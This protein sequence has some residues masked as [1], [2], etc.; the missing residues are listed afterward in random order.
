MELSA[1]GHAAQNACLQAVALNL[2]TVVI[3]AFEDDG[4][5]AVLRLP[6]QE[7][8]LYLLPVGRTDR[9]GLPGGAER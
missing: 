1:G 8:P 7:R 9:H 5:S 2:G 6:D 3:G 4:V